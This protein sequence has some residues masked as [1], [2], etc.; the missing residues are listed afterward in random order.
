M[1]P[2]DQAVRYAINGPSQAHSDPTP[3]PTSSR[4]GLVFSG[5]TCGLSVGY[6]MSS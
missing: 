4:R 2:E 5:P 6:V 3:G 1:R